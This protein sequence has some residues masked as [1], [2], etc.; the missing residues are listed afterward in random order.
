MLSGVPSIQEGDL[1]LKWVPNSSEQGRG[2]VSIER[3]LCLMWVFSSSEWGAY[4]KWVP[5]SS[6]LGVISLVLP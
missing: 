5:N 1:C 6:E 3:G 4:L 2:H